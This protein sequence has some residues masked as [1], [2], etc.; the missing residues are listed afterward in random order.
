MSL[1][2]S[3][4]APLT[5]L[6]SLGAAR[7][8]RSRLWPPWSAGRQITRTC[9]GPRNR[10]RCRVTEG[11][12]PCAPVNA[13]LALFFVVVV[14]T[15]L[16]RHAL[17]QRLLCIFFKW[18]YFKGFTVSFYSGRRTDIFAYRGPPKTPRV[19]APHPVFDSTSPGAD[20]GPRPFGPCSVSVLFGGGNEGAALARD[21]D[22]LID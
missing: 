9:S 1:V 2:R 8:R 10:E 17:F 22:V 7:V 6:V 5:A 3:K 12:R 4:G 21:T 13:I 11:K 14:R 16:P 18:S 20:P 19:F 15:Y